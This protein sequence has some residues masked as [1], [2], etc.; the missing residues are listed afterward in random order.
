MKRTIGLL[1]LV[2]IV[3]GPVWADTITFQNNVGTYDGGVDAGVRQEKPYYN[4]GGSA[5]C[6]SGWEDQE[7]ITFFRFDDMFGSAAYQLPA[8]QTITSA[9]LKLFVEGMDNP[10]ESRTFNASAMTVPVQMG[11]QNNY[12]ASEGDVC[13]AYRAFSD[14][15]P[16]QWNAGAGSSS[17]PVANAD[18][19]TTDAASATF[20]FSGTGWVEWDVTEIVK[21]W[22]AGTLD[23]EGFIVRQADDTHNRRVNFTM[24]EGGG[25]AP[26]LEITYVPEPAT[27]SL[28]A[29]GGLGVLIRRKR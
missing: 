23:N 25:N 9:K 24:E 8:G 16:G 13:Y 21:K 2:A 10:S 6:G 26:A 27:M 20:G 18:Y 1:M 22:Y 29:L 12:W 17:G 3:C 14:Y 5:T 28:L 4:Y 19:T 15:T 11:T 7:L